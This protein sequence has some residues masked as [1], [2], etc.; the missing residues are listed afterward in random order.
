MRSHAT[1]ERA[2]DPGAARRAN[3]FGAVSPPLALPQHSAGGG[4]G[5]SALQFER[6]ATGEGTALVSQLWEGSQ[7]GAGDSEYQP[8]DTG[9]DHRYDSLTSQSLHEQVP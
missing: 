9:G 8:G 2:H 5:R 3:I 1:G 6:K 4:S 7:T